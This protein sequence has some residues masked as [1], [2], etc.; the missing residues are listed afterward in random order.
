MLKARHKP[1][2]RIRYE[3]THPTVS[4]R[5]DKELYDK[6]KEIKDTEGKSFADILKEA[7]GIQKRS[8]QGAYDRGYKAGCANGLTEGREFSL[9]NCSRCGKALDWDLNRE[10]DVELLT[11]AVNK[12]RYIH[13]ECPVP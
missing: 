10:T 1:P 12:A 6:L 2:S 9:G 3:Q 4:T 7:L 11:K 8:T 5:V 13:S